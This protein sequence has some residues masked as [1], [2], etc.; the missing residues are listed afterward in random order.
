M[1]KKYISQIVDGIYLDEYL[2]QIIQ[3]A[4]LIRLTSKYSVKKKLEWKEQ[5]PIPAFSGILFIQSRWDE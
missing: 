2:I 4:S 1:P 3:R 5:T